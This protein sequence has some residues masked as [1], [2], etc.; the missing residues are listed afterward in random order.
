[1][2]GPLSMVEGYFNRLVNAYLSSGICIAKRD[3]Q[4]IRVN[5]SLAKI[6][7]RAVGGVSRRRS[8]MHIVVE[9]GEFSYIL[10]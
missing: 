8:L 4:L 1:M 7:I 2:A 5:C 10:C 9:L 3:S 6:G